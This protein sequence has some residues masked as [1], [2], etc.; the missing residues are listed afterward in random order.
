MTNKIPF[1]ENDIRIPDRTAVR[2]PISHIHNNVVDA[3]ERQKMIPLAMRTLRTFGI[4]IRKR[5][6]PLR[7][8]ILFDDSQAVR[9]RWEMAQTMVTEETVDVEVESVAEYSYGDSVCLAESLETV[10]AWIDGTRIDKLIERFEGS[11]L[12]SR[13]LALEELLRIDFSLE[14][15]MDDRFHPIAG[16]LLED[17]SSYI[18]RCNRPIK[19]TEYANQGYSS[20]LFRRVTL[21]LLLNTL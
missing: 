19:I 1:R 9:K 6:N 2:I 17:G 20:S 10:E 13:A 12:N 7:P 11:I 8:G 16:K 3:G 4:R 18:F 21:S 14:I 5:R 15:L